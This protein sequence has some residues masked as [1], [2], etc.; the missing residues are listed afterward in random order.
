M[1]S[2]LA[3]LNGQPVQL[4]INRLGPPS[5]YTQE[6]SDTVYM[7]NQTSMVPAASLRSPVVGI[8]RAPAENGYTSALYSGV[9]VPVECNV[10]I[11][12]DAQGRIKES[13]VHWGDRRLP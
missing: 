2:V 6:G 1:E 7:W 9:A 5:S 4:V 13:A 11:V 3:P 10:Q 8:G 12:A